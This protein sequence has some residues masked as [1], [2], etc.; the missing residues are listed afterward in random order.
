MVSA[1]GSILS[2]AQKS[3]LTSIQSTARLIDDVQLRLASGLDVNSAIDN[4]QNFFSA[5]ALEFRANDLNRRI[6]A[7]GQSIRT[8]Q[9]TQSG[10]EAS[11][12]ILD[13]A[14]AYLKDVEKRYA[15]GEIELE[16]IGDPTN[17]TE[18][19]PTAG[20]FINYAGGQDSGAPITVNG[21]G[22]EIVIDGNIWR[23]LAVNYTITPD[24]VLEFEYSSSLIPEIA[25]IG[26][27]NDNVFNNSVDRF[28][29]YGTQA[30]GLTYSAPRP[31]YQY[32]GGGA[33]QSYS[34]PV[35]TFFTGTFSHLTFIND[36]DAGLAGNSTYTN[37]TLREGPL[38]FADL[39]PPELQED[40]EAILD[41]LDRITID[42]NYRGINLLAKENLTTIFN[43]DGTSRLVTEGIDSSSRGLGLTREDF[44]SIEAVQAKI[45]EVREAK[46]FLRE[47]S[48]AV[49]LDLNVIQTRETFTRELVNGLLA[50]RDDLT[51]ADQNEVGAEFLAL[52]VRE[53]VGISALAFGQANIGDFL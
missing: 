44:N 10:I 33:A 42:A 40:Y 52:S 9:E 27:D 34:I 20:D 5:E 11:L 1:I 15:A 29:L 50:G 6:D 46:E 30:T 2:P 53:Q 28:F 25:A 49:A 45:E 19:L 39:A 21:G 31:T 3:Q 35:G 32:T 38:E 23:R 22:S 37:I 7:I 43:E 24:T 48:S 16:P 8:L 51:V 17:L 14:D 47:Y 18:I 41:Q 13:T 12:D 26:F 36:D 4:P